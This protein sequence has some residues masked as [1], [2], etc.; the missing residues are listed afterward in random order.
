[1]S[2]GSLEDM[3]RFMDEHPTAGVAGVRLLNPDGSF[4][5]SFAAFPTLVQEFLMLSGLGRVLLRSTYPG[6][7]PEVEK[8]PQLVQ[9]VQG[10]CLLVRRQA[11]EEVGGLDEGIFMYSEEV[12]WCYRFVRAGWQVWYLPHVTIVHH[13]GQSTNKRK[14]RMEAELYRSRVFFF[15]KH[16]G[17]SAALF[18]EVL[19]YLLTLPKILTHGFLRL[20]TNGKRGRTVTSLKELHMTLTSR[21]LG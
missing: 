21:H 19:I 1:M 6:F 8:G 2:A 3:V 10:A 12:D 20:L 5:A 15:R 11:I 9:Y 13:G 18:L 14:A 17:R 4:Q 16:Y 7:G